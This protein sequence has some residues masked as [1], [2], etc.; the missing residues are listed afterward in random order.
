MKRALAALVVLAA[1]P[2]AADE[3]KAS[4]EEVEITSVPDVP[5]LTAL[6]ATSNKLDRPDSGKSLA[7]AFATAL[8]RDG[9]I[10][11]GIGIE[12]G[13]RALRLD[14][15]WTYRDYVDSY[16]KKVLSR[17]AISIGTSKNSASTEDTIAGTVPDTQGAVGVRIVL[18]DGSDPLLAPGYVA[19]AE[20]ARTECRDKKKLEFPEC[21]VKKADEYTGSIEPP[22]NAGGLY[23]A[24]VETWNFEESK[25]KKADADFLHTWVAG[26]LPICKW[27][28]FAFGGVWKHPWAEDTKDTLSIAARLRFGTPKT[29]FIGD[30]TWFAR[31]PDADPEG[32]WAAGIEV[33]VAG[34]GWLT[35]SAGTDLGGDSSSAVTLLSSLKYGMSPTPSFAVENPRETG[36]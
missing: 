11:T 16:V 18:W 23:L 31:R 13:L 25:L 6:D 21:L 12:I 27:G 28:Q 8:D 4:T 36:K 5:A 17:S 26:A 22:W 24:L 10:K 34:A 32:R 9:T 30:G 15:K 20:W 35:L 33:K 1:S 2:A 19:K 29:R 7:A 14:K 3:E